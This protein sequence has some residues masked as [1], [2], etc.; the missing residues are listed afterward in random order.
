[1]FF[2]LVQSVR[3]LVVAVPKFT[4]EGF[5]MIAILWAH[6]V[7]LGGILYVAARAIHWILFR[8]LP[9]RLAKFLVFA[10]IAA[11]VLL[12]AFFEVYRVPGH[13]HAPPA[14]IFRFMKEI[15]T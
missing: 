6:V 9:Q 10:L 14:N 3:G 8:V 5:W 7:I 2:I 15:A 4:A 13:D 12:A 11:L 1:L